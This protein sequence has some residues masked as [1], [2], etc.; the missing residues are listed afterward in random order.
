MEI[1]ESFPE[2]W[3]GGEGPFEKGK[4]VR[5]E[6]RSCFQDTKLGTSA[7]FSAPKEKIFSRGK[8]KVGR[9]KEGR[10][11]CCIS[12]KEKRLGWVQWVFR[13]LNVQRRFRRGG[14]EERE[15]V[16]CSW[17]GGSRGTARQCEFWGG[18]C[19]TVL[20]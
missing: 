10:R 1:L 6:K 19:F 7:W 16:L 4:G 5:L 3:L 12:G 11:R 8:G 9:L 2:L 13:G 14:E 17:S 18:G 20:N 15:A